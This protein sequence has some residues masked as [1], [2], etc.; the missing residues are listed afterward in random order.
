MRPVWE[1]LFSGG[2]ESAPS[3]HPVVTNGSQGGRASAGGGAVALTGNEHSTLKSERVARTFSSIGRRNE[4]LRA[5]L[6]SLELS[7]RDIEAIRTQFH[8]ALSSID[9]T[10]IEIERTK[11]AHLEAER[12]LEGLT[13]AHERLEN[14]RA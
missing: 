10:L 12:K 11:I 13:A 3:Q 4:T 2:P 9:Q 6:D 5:Q 7:F 8:D 1:K 14:D